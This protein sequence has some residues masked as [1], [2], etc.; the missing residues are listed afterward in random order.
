MSPP[1]PK[2]LLRL[3]ALNAWNLTFGQSPECSP[4]AL[5]TRGVD[6]PH[7]RGSRELRDSRDSWLSRG[8]STLPFCSTDD[9]T[10]LPSKYC[11]AA[12]SISA[13]LLP[14][15]LGGGGGGGGFQRPAFV[16][17]AR[18]RSV[19]SVSSSA[20]SPPPIARRTT[21]VVAGQVDD[22]ELLKQQLQHKT[23]VAEAATVY[24][25]SLEDRLQEQ[26]D[27]EQRLSH[28]E[29]F[30]AQQAADGDWQARVGVLEAELHAA[31]AEAGKQAE[32]AARLRKERD[33]HRR[34]ADRVAAEVVEA[35]Q[36]KAED[37]AKDTAAARAA[38]SEA[39]VRIE[40]LDD[41]RQQADRSVAERIAQA[42]S[43]L[44]VRE[45]E[46]RRECSER[47][48]TAEDRAEEY[49]RS[50]ARHQAALLAELRQ[51]ESEPPRLMAPSPGTAA[52]NEI[53][54]LREA[55]AQTE[56]KFQR[57]E[58]EVR[59]V[60]MQHETLEKEMHRSSTLRL[61]AE[62]PAL[63][64]LG[65]AT[66]N[67]TRLIAQ[68]GE[69]TE[70][71]AA[72]DR[73]VRALDQDLRELR[74]NA[75]VGGV[76]S[77]AGNGI[78][79]TVTEVRCSEL[80]Q[81]ARDSE[82][83]LRA[84]LAQND[85]LRSDVDEA[86]RA[87][88]ALAQRLSEVQKE[89][90]E[91]LGELDTE[92]ERARACWAEAEAVKE[93][94]RT[95]SSLWGLARDVYG[96]QS[97]SGQV[98]A[99]REEILILKAA[100][101]EN[102][103]NARKKPPPPPVEERRREG[104]SRQQHQEIERH[105]RERCERAERL[106]DDLR[107][108]EQGLTRR[109]KELKQQLEQSKGHSASLRSAAAAA[110]SA[111]QRAQEA[112]S[113]REVEILAL[114]EEVA[115]LRRGMVKEIREAE[116]RASAEAARRVG[117]LERELG[118]CEDR[119]EHQRAEF[120]LQVAQL[121]AQQAEAQERV[122]NQER[123]RDTERIAAVS[124]SSTPMIA[125][126]Q[127]AELEAKLRRS[128]RQF[129]E[130]QAH[131]LSEREARDEERNGL[132]RDAQERVAAVEGAASSAML[133]LEGQLDKAHATIARLQEDNTR[134]T[135]EARDK[136]ETLVQVVRERD[137]MERAHQLAARASV[138]A[139]ELE[140][141]KTPGGR[142]SR[143]GSAEVESHMS[144][145]RIVRP[146]E[147][148][149]AA[150]GDAV[151]GHIERMREAL[152]QAGKPEAEVNRY[153]GQL[154]MSMTRG[155]SPSDIPALALAP[156][157]PLAT[158][159]AA[160]PISSPQYGRSR[161]PPAGG[162]ARLVSN[163]GVAKKRSR[164]PGGRKGYAAK[165]K[166]REGRSEEPRSEERSPQATSPDLPALSV[167]ARVLGTASSVLSPNRMEWRSRSV[168][169]SPPEAIADAEVDALYQRIGLSSLAHMAAL[170][171]ST[172]T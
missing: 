58:A 28:L 34:A 168:S 93:A 102:A 73:V 169:A 130:L 39:V 68:V 52:S 92:R 138:A 88:D 127:I 29:G 107:Q 70:R 148:Q 55:L 112:K 64:R 165:H 123:E 53:A 38:L 84:A 113:A 40:R 162:A 124:P 26:R 37:L 156:H 66:V 105:L 46:M 147:H 158:P 170:K 50:V 21:P 142:P 77:P 78:S 101:E 19:S 6:P 86:R 79:T 27:V 15:F 61:E 22:V 65:D 12:S 24:S 81:A 63:R 43:A 36:K 74:T 144:P 5:R 159:P 30:L 161:T 151:W 152:T 57:A 119:C 106:V 1:R 89:R 7:P 134:L 108:K 33:A 137:D 99:L 72:R 115:S 114:K 155:E 139:G 2:S 45:Q 67:E 103:Q 125:V 96:E 8:T 18:G 154:Y 47:V 95:A 83:R 118:M 10:S 110:K 48:A 128:T 97:E 56:L 120:E 20:R 62:S 25:K 11:I 149:T 76:G 141:R 17:G 133:E 122:L 164:T 71:V 111:T 132:Q 14:L 31:R 4:V 16:A 90:Q 163:Q 153:V 116:L 41:E 60:R 87:H 146:V 85:S 35:A 166:Q 126:Q 32:A 160:F 49:E 140:A 143:S 167:A 171:T 42:E 82:K 80:A 145:T 23:K 100:Q 117:Q 75:Q 54:A 135:A 136:E 44:R 109:E 131:V 51:R 172:K 9:T 121:Q 69:L 3:P 98:N 129:H 13:E 157:L 104:H 150:A 59:C 94:T 91:L